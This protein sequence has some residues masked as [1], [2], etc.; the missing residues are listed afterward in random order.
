MLTSHGVLTRR[1]FRCL[2]PGLSNT[3]VFRGQWLGNSRPR[4]DCLVRQQ[5]IDPGGCD[6]RRDHRKREHVKSAS[7]MNVRD[8]GGLHG[9]D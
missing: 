2:E 1:G 5:P 4:Q 3:T 7:N 9:D 8:S 6:L